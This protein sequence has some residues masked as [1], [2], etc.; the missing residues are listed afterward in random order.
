MLYPSIDNLLSQIGSKYLLVN[1]VS[2]RLTQ[3][4]KTGHCPVFFYVQKNY[5]QIS[6]GPV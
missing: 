4:K 2:K 6:I 3:I 1:V 5:Y